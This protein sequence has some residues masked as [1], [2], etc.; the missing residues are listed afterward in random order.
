MQQ[1]NPI[2]AINYIKRKPLQISKQIAKTRENPSGHTFL[3]VN[4]TTELYTRQKNECPRRIRKTHR[5][6]H[7]INSDIT[8]ANKECVSMS[9]WN[10]FRFW[11][12][13]LLKTTIGTEPLLCGPI[14]DCICTYDRK[15]KVTIQQITD[16]LQCQLY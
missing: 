15:E 11:F 8:L 3:G 13:A 7:S 4:K 2:N 5:S 1:I 10:V 16:N 9:D 12:T 6:T 14:Y